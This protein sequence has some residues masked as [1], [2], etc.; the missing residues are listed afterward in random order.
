[1][2]NNC[3]LPKLN[4]DKVS[5]IHQTWFPNLLASIVFSHCPNEWT[6]KFDPRIIAKD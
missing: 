2:D 6:E 5:G 3:I 1:M 4:N